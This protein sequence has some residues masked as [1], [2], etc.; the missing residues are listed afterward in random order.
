M[1]NSSRTPNPSDGSSEVKATEGSRGGL[2]ASVRAARLP[3]QTTS[4]LNDG[5]E[6]SSAQLTSREEPNLPSTKKPNLSFPPPRRQS[7]GY[8]SNDSLP[9]SPLLS[10]PAT[11]DKATQTPSPTGQVMGHALQCLS[12]A[13]RGPRMSRTH[14][15]FP[16]PSRRQRGNLVR[17]MQEEQAEAFGQQLRLIGDEYNRL[18]MQRRVAARER[19]D[20][21]PLNL[22]RHINQEPVTVLCVSLMLLVI[23]RIIYLQG[24]SNGQNHS[25]V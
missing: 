5:G 13:G 18:L 22:L 24:S 21:I 8:F 11:A 6:Q 9:S 23:G 1:Y 12:G 20:V 16:N 19:E 14:G 10:K 2:P 7:S 15:L 25:Q 4:S 3:A 17:A